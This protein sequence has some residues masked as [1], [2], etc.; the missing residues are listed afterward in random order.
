M[1]EMFEKRIYFVNKAMNKAT[2]ALL[3]IVSYFFTLLCF[4]HLN[5]VKQECQVVGGF[6]L[7]Q[8]VNRRSLP[9]VATS[10]NVSRLGSLLPQS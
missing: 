6:V 3:I 8:F 10:G 1:N 4:H 5:T 2:N 7:P 9:E